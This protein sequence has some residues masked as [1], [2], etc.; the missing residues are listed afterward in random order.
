MAL[1][2]VVSIA[3]A[4]NRADDERILRIN[5]DPFSELRNVLIERTAVRHVIQSPALVEKRIARN[6][7]TPFFMKQSQNSDITKAQ[8]DCS[9]TAPGPEFRG[10]DFEISQT[11]RRGNCGLWC[12]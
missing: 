8:F 7:D 3:N 9:F 4:M 5:F 12:C 6:D 2:F 10:E 11:K 1:E